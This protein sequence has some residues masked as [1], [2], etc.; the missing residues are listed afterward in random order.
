ML[1]QMNSNSLVTEQ[2]WKQTNKNICLYENWVSKL[3]CDIEFFVSYNGH[4]KSAWKNIPALLLLK[5]QIS[6]LFD[7]Q[8]IIECRFTL[9]GVN[10]I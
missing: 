1:L 3:N 6:C 5:L 10:D 2:N 7:I 9:K 8:A 4:Q